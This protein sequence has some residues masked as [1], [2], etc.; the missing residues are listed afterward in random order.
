M[1]LQDRFTVDNIEEKVH[2]ARRTLTTCI[3]RARGQLD[4]SKLLEDLGTLSE[5]LHDTQ[6]MLGRLDHG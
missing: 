4:K 1:N 2:N 3:L 6:K 5:E